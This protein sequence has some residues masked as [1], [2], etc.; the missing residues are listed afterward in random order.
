MRQA[1][2]NVDGKIQ[3]ALWVIQEHAETLEA[4]LQRYYGLN[5]ATL[6]VPGSGLTWR[7]L[8]VLIDHLPPEAA[9]ITA[10]RNDTPDQVL[11]RNATDPTKGNWSNLE[12]LV[13]TAIDEIRNSQWMYA[14]AH[15]ERTVRRPQPIPRPGI[16]P[17][18]RRTMPI[19]DARKIDPRLRGIPD[20]Q[21]QDMLDRLTGG[22]R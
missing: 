9:L 10:I 11:A 2:E 16:K 6:F 19:E 18:T 8:L 21:V 5:L 15:S 7:R 20:D 12:N 4:D 22:A 17:V 13:A 3:K 1:G 14:S